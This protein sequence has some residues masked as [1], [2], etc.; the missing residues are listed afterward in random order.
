M[1][2]EPSPVPLMAVR[3]VRDVWESALGIASDPANTDWTPVIS[4]GLASAPGTW[5]PRI[6]RVL[7][8][9]QGAPVIMRIV[10]EYA[11]VMFE[12]LLTLGT[13]H[14]CVTS[15]EARTTTPAGTLEGAL[16]PEVEVAAVD[17][18]PWVL[19]RRVIPPLE[20][21]RAAPT[22]HVGSGRRVTLDD[23]GPVQASVKWSIA[24][25]ADSGVGLDAAEFAVASDLLLR[26]VSENGHVWEVVQPGAL[27][28]AATW[29]LAGARSATSRRS[30]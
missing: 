27:A 1:L 4:S 14:V 13:P 15:R 16:D 28:R 6:G 30:A 12:A 24:A 21:L 23:L 3:L 26:R 11:D 25:L 5:E 18:D 10:S 2:D 19:I 29:Q 7:S 8:A 22:T 9:L 17:G 20:T